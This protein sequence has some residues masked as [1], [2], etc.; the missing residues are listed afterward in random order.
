MHKWCFANFAEEMMRAQIASG[1]RGD[2]PANMC[3]SRQSKLYLSRVEKTT[4][5]KFN[6]KYWFL[7]RKSWFPRLIFFCFAYQ[8][9]TEKLTKKPLKIRLFWLNT[10][11]LNSCGE[12]DQLVVYL[13]FAKNR[14]AK[15]SKSAKRSFASKI[16]IWNI[17][18]RSYASRF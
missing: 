3:D 5:Q 10:C 9:L 15:R 18:R 7:L 4:Q 16:K 11:S 1:R 14:W 2:K 8:Y 17:V 12:S 13:N 6:F